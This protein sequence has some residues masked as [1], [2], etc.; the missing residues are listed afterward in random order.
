MKTKV[1]RYHEPNDGDFRLLRTVAQKN[2][3]AKDIIDLAFS[4]WKRA[5]EDTNSQNRSL[6]R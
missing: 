5:H 3:Y 4:C 1:I 6:R 2:L